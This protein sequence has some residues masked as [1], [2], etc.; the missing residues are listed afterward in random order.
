MNEQSKARRRELIRDYKQTPRD[1]GV[2]RIVNTRNGKCYVA[3]SRDVNAR[4]NRHKMSLKN[5]LEAVRQLQAEWNQFGADAFQFEVLDLLEPSDKPGY[6]PD[7]DLAVLE[8]LWIEK[9]E[10]WDD[11]GYNKR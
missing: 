5:N 11:K 7:E 3:S 4:L 6:N 1:M 8:A 2:Y 10:P 9:L